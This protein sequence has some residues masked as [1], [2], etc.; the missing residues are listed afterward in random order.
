MGLPVEEQLPKPAK[1]EVGTRSEYQIWDILKVVTVPQS[2]IINPNG[3]PE[4]IR[5]PFFGNTTFYNFGP[6]TLTST[7]NSLSMNGTY[8]E[9]I[10]QNLFIVP[11]LS[12]TNNTAT[13]TGPP[14][15]LIRAAVGFS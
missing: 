8:T 7:V 12:F 14:Q 2:N 4:G 10:N 13:D 6:D 3:D 11:S 5:F 15:Y 1:A 9:T